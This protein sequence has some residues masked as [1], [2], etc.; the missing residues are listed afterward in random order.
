MARWAGNVIYIDK[1]PN[2]PYK[3]W[4]W[5][6]VTTEDLRRFNIPHT[7]PLPRK[8]TKTKEITVTRYEDS[9][10]FQ[11]TY[12]N[13]YEATVQLPWR[14]KSGTKKFIL[15][16]DGE[17]V[18]IRAQKSLTNQAIFAWIKSWASPTVR[19]VTPGK[20]THSIEGEKLAH[21]AYFVYFIL[22]EDSKAI[23]IGLAKDPTK[24]LKALQTSSPAKLAI[25][26]TMQVDGLKAAQE[27]EQS[28]HKQFSEIRL[29]GEWFK[30]EAGLLEYISQL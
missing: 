21:Q 13:T 25:I 29:A 16:I 28:L 10:P 1:D 26:K 30:A 17:L 9:V 6:E 27:L 14:G 11:E 3:G 8:V 12:I 5:V 20:R 19:I 4:G 2:D 18:E 15:N 7:H 24:R 22:N 23:K